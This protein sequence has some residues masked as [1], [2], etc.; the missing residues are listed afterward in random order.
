MQVRDWLP[1]ALVESLLIVMSI[2]LALAL[3]EWREERERQER[4][5]RSLGNFFNELSQNASRIDS[6]RAYHRGVLQLLQDRA[7]TD[8]VDAVEFRNI[9]STLQPVVLT[10]SAWDTAVATGVL[11]HMDFELVSALTL[12][13]N[14]QLRFDENYRTMVRTLLAPQS[15]AADNLHASAYNAA[16]FV[17]ELGQAESELRA[18]YEQTLEILD[19]TEGFRSGNGGR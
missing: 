15:L 14:T 1:R 18:Y 11:S 16:R 12:T 9:M 2:L 7:A 19:A 6:V 13:Y 10:S 5:E 8:Q 3:D 17:A 4:V